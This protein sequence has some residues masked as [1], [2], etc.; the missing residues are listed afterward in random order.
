MERESCEIFSFA[1]VYKAS[2]EDMREV[3]SALM[4]ASGIRNAKKLSDFFHR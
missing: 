1:I 2:K 3:V 4:D